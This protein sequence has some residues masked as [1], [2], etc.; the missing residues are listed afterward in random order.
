MIDLNQDGELTSEIS[1]RETHPT[2]AH[3]RINQ[4]VYKIEIASNGDHVKF[5]TAPGIV[6][7]TKS[8]DVG[9]AF[10]V[11]DLKGISGEPFSIATHRGQWILVDF[12]GEWCGGCVQELP[13]LI[14]LEKSLANDD[15]L[16]VGFLVTGD[17]DAAQQVVQNANISW[18][19]VLIPGDKA[20]DEYLV[21]G[22][23]TKFLISPDGIIAAVNPKTQD[24]PSLVSGSK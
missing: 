7:D 14:E 4:Q 6:V 16:I 13:R 3:L 20:H 5:T 18:Q 19:Q 10:P 12:W 1:S 22:F 9:D 23:P 24:I 15:F 17:V 21:S 11:E 2:P 8:L